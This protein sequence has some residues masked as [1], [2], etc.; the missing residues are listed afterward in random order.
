MQVR[1]AGRLLDQDKLNAA[2]HFLKSAARIANSG[3]RQSITQLAT[4]LNDTAAQRLVEADQKFQDAD[5]IEAMTAYRSLSRMSQ[6]AVAKQAKQ[7]LKEA[8][9]NPAVK[10]ARREIRAAALYEDVEVMLFDVGDG[11]PSAI[12]CLGCSDCK[13][14]R[15]GFGAESVAIYDALAEMATLSKQ[16]NAPADVELATQL[17]ADDQVKLL[18]RLEKISK[19]FSDTPTGRKATFEASGR[20]PVGPSHRRPEAADRRAARPQHGQ[21]LPAGGPTRKGRGTLSQS[22]RRLAR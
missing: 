17:A 14:K 19:R 9:R 13:K 16:L 1:R 8:V 6:L 4:K 20:C 21:A 10:T 2:Y 15:E 5:Y 22:D 3:Q 11:E 18:V 7:K 12:D